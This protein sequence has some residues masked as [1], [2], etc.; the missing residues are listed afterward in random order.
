MLNWSSSS[1]RKR[2]PGVSKLSFSLFIQDSTAANPSPLF[3]LVL[4]EV[5]PL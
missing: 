3:G 4:Y 2:G 5:C 1:L